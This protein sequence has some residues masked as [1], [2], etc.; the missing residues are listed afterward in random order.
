MG[1]S[2][3]ETGREKQQLKNQTL[4]LGI[5]FCGWQKPAETN[6]LYMTQISHLIQSSCVSWEGTDLCHF[7]VSAPD[8]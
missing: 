5:K 1:Q 3:E 6:D 8:K 2:P 4:E 7:W